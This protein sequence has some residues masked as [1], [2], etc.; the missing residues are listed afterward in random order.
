M[1]TKADIERIHR[2]I[3]AE[4]AA[5]ES[6]APA[7]IIGQCYVTWERVKKEQKHARVHK[8]TI[9]REIR[10]SLVLDCGHHLSLEPPCPKYRTKCRQCAKKE[11]PGPLSRGAWSKWQLV[12][13]S[14]VEP[15]DRHTKA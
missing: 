10:K 9:E 14:A 2:E 13:V 4:R 5:L 1:F 7:N 11:P 3:E 12:S 15:D 6:Q 8:L